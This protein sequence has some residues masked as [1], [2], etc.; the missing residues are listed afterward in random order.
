[1][2]E[3]TKKQMMIIGLGTIAINLIVF[4][5]L[6]VVLARAYVAG[7]AAVVVF[8]VVSGTI[9]AV[10]VYMNFADKGSKLA[11]YYV[12]LTAGIFLW[13][14]LGEIPDHYYYFDL[15][16]WRLMPILLTAILVFLMA[17]F[18][19]K[20]RDGIT[21]MFLMFIAIWTW[22]NLMVTQFHMLG[23]THWTTYLGAIF[24][25]IIGVFCILKVLKSEN[26]WVTVSLSILAIIHLWNIVEYVQAWSGGHSHSH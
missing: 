4:G 12:S 6:H 1:M 19:Y 8:G 2:S 15:S 26:L 3:Y 13:G 10:A 11:Q 14:L 5:I 9:I 21:I 22:H 18:K 24:C 25:A 16:S 23:E 20:I 17:V 7:T